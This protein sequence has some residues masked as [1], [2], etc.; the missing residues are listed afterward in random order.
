MVG[1]KLAKPAIFIQEYQKGW[2]QFIPF[3]D[4][5]AGHSVYRFIGRNWDWFGRGHFSLS[6][7]PTTVNQ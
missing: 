5:R 4:H 6:S 3:F 1:Y 7:E 2:N